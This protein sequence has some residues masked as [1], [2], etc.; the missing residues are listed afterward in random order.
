MATKYEVQNRAQREHMT[1]LV[2]RLSDRELASPAGS[3]GWTVAAL[4]GHLA[5]WDWR[6]AI[7]LRR[8][9]QLGKR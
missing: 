2:S 5:F 1:D 3:S 4:L 8:S 9:T 6:G 7:L